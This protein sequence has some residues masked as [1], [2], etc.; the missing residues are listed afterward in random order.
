M[1]AAEIPAQM[2]TIDATA[3]GG[4]EVLQVG[5][6]DTPTPAVGEVLIRVHA[7]GVNRP[8]L[9]QRMGLYPPPP[10]ASPILGLEVAGEVVALG[11]G[12]R[13]LHLGDRVCALV[14]GGGY[15]EFCT[16][17]SLQCL[18]IP[19]QFDWV[20]AAAIPETFFTV[21]HNVFE[22][23]QLQA[24]QRLL[25]HGGS[26]GIGTT[27]I[28]LAKA[29]GAHVAVTVGSAEK[30]EACLLLGAERAI[31][32]R[33]EDFAAALRDWTGGVGVD[34]ILDMVGG[35]YFPRNIES[36]AVGGR[37][38]VIAFLR[39]TKAQVDLSVILR[40]RLTV[41]GSAL[42]TRSV[43]DKGEMAMTLHREVWPLLDAGAVRPVIYATFP[44]E[45]AAQA[46]RTMEQG[47]HI[48][49]LMLRVR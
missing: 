9:L 34:V 12:V 43:A 28:Q 31:N 44:L 22:R 6:H 8:D 49:K 20:Q 47:H 45:E 15:A 42:R 33:S 36:L 37:L 29:R 39:G 41:T 3:P 21:W 19:R 24:G 17:P 48:G 27:A 30:A 35:E 14:A 10:G 32:Y 1:S 40:R 4:P 46:H 2:R 7:A 38:V 25:I 26:S 16:A 23:G 11:E 5:I 13:E 18:P